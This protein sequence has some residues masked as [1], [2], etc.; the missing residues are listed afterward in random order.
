M[1]VALIRL[2]GVNLAFVIV[3]P[4]FI[5][6][7]SM[8]PD[9]IPYS[10]SELL[11]SLQRFF[12]LAACFLIAFSSFLNFLLICAKRFL[13]RIGFLST[14]LGGM[15]IG[16]LRPIFL[17]LTTITCVVHSVHAPMLLAE[18]AMFFGASFLGDSGRR[19]STRLLVS[20]LALVGSFLIGLCIGLFLCTYALYSLKRH[21]KQTHFHGS[22]TFLMKVEVVLPCK[23]AH[24]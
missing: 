8:L 18:V 2:G 14:F 5:S 6:T 21:K 3:S 1:G 23:W 15:E 16:F 4:K 17:I 10:E 11:S 20:F 24:L 7:F 19:L 22:H 13:C 9:P 12:D